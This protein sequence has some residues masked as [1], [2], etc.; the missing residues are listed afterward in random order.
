MTSEPTHP[1]PALNAR[2]RFVNA[3]G[4]RLHVADYGGAGPPLLLVHGTGLCAQVWEVMLPSLAPHFSVLALDRRGH[5]DS[6]KP[7]AGYD[8]VSLS[9]DHAAVVDGLGIRGALALGHSSGATT[10]GIAARREPGLFSRIAMVDPIV[11]PRRDTRPPEFL[12]LGRRVM[13]STARRRAEWPRAQEMFDTLKARPPFA[14]WM[15]NALWA[16]VRH[17]A[18]AAPDGRV[19]L[20]CPPTLEASMYDHDGDLDLFAKLSGLS[21]PTLVVRGGATDRFPRDT[22]ERAAA[23]MGMARLVE[24][25]GLSHFAPMED[26]EAVS[27]A[28][29]PFLL[30]RRAAP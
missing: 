4:C 8:F 5:G 12:A 3:D 11:F 14:T 20:K 13:E 1:H 27:R 6:D 24:L 21:T 9:R 25:P 7:A 23:A 16:Y 15:D 26:A 2:S 30:D 19:T 17:G 29:L 22:A 10:L 28:V 18:S